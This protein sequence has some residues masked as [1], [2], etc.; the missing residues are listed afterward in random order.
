MIRIK[1]ILPTVALIAVTVVGAVGARA[2]LEAEHPPAH[3]WSQKGFFGTFDRAALQRGFQVYSEVCSA[4]HSLK[5]VAFRNLTALGF[6]KDDVKA[7][8]AQRE[9]EDGPNDEGDMYMRP[10]RP[11]DHFPPPFANDQAARAANNGALPPDLSLII[12]AREDGDDYIYALLT[13]FKD[14]APEGFHLA[15]GMNYNPYFP[16]GQIAMPPPLFEDSVEYADGTPATVENMAADV[17]TFLAWAAEPTLEA[18][19]HLGFKVMAFLLILAVMMFF[20][21]RRVWN[22]LK[23]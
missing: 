15:D 18:R 20:V 21:N 3:H 19:K 1:S 2:A 17:T 16:G 8:A 22:K 5:Y 7:I 12:K 4:C 6:S 9:V 10:A 13:G 11:S 14:E 23:P